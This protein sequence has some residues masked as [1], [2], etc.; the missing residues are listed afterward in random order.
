MRV[1]VTK[2]DVCLKEIPDTSPQWHVLVAIH[3]ID[4]ESTDPATKETSPRPAY[5]IDDYVQEK[6][7]DSHGCALTVFK[8]A[9]GNGNSE[10]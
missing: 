9:L 8:T 6:L 4:G 2:C 10:G 3:K 1:T 7:V 5:K